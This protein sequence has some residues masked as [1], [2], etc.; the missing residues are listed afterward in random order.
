MATRIEAQLK[1]VAR[2]YK[3]RRSRSK[4]QMASLRVRDL[5]RLF[6]ARYGHTLPDDDAGRDDAMVMAHHLACL[7]GNPAERVTNWLELR[8]PWFTIGETKAL[9]AE[10]LTH[11]I[12]WRADK[13]AWR[14]RLT[15]ADRSTLRITTIGAIDAS[16]D[17]RTA[18]R[19]ERNRKAQQSRRRARGVKVRAEYEAR[20]ISRAKPWISLKMSRAAWY[21]AGKPS[22]E[23]SPCTA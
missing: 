12:R 2:R 9:I 4:P 13:L 8:C 10:V 16:K 11:P 1:E 15:A 19:K 17:E 6:S 21:R 14:M 23:T 18:Q 22:P 5:N 20:A 7:S 3:R